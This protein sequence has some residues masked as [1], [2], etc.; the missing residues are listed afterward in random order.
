VKNFDAILADVIA[1]EIASWEKDLGRPAD[2]ERRAAIAQ[3]VEA[4]LRS[5]AIADFNFV[6]R[7]Y[8]WD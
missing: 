8:G 3:D 1:E 7:A 2:A 4:E 5:E 6:D